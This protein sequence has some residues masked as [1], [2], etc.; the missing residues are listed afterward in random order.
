[1][2]SKYPTR[3]GSAAT[4]GSQRPPPGHFGAWFKYR[5]ILDW[6][7]A[8][9]GWPESCSIYIRS[10]RGREG[11]GE[12]GRGGGEEEEEDEEGGGGEIRHYSLLSS[13]SEHRIKDHEP[14]QK[15]VSLKRRQKDTTVLN[16]NQLMKQVLQL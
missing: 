15:L 12:G 16:T 1:M 3:A 2:H 5:D 8:Q 7:K 10:E 6:L 13:S 11:G 9:E 4:K 14:S